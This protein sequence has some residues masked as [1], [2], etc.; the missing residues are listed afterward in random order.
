MDENMRNMIASVKAVI[1]TT[2]GQLEAME[3]EP[4]PDRQLMAAVQ[5]NYERAVATL[6]TLKKI[7]GAAATAAVEP[8]QPSAP[9]STTADEPI[10]I[11]RHVDHA[12]QVIPPAELDEHPVNEQALE[13]STASQ[14]T[15]A[16]TGERVAHA[17]PSSAPASA[18]D[19]QA[20]PVQMTR[21]QYRKML[22]KRKH[23]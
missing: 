3:K 10:N 15:A 16:P 21:A 20:A 4:D 11:T 9:A 1:E 12:F 18:E 8:A 7:N 14:P 22:K 2:R 5:D 19:D 13:T 6:R 23:K 17:T